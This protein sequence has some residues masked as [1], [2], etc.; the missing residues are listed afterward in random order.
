MMKPLSAKTSKLITCLYTPSLSL[1]SDEPEL[2]TLLGQ[3]KASMVR[4][5][6]RFVLV[7][8]VSVAVTGL[9][10]IEEAETAAKVGNEYNGLTEDDKKRF[11]VQFDGE[12][13]RDCGL[14]LPLPSKPGHSSDAQILYTLCYIRAEKLG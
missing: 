3:D 8:D 1:L 9:R 13:C 11:R 6:I 14:C 5:A 4:S 10:S 7:Q 12:Y 2:K